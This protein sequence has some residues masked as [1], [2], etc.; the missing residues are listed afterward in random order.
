MVSIYIYFLDAHGLFLETLGFF[1][2][3]AW[4]QI[5]LLLLILSI[6]LVKS[7]VIFQS[8]FPHPKSRNQNA[9]HTT[10]VVKNP[11]SGSPLCTALLY[12]SSVCRSPF[13]VLVSTSVLDATASW[14]VVIKHC[15]E[16]F[17]CIISFNPL[18]GPGSRHCIIPIF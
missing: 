10:Y 7:L 6:A 11:S 16:L 12:W 5:S 9:A 2:E 1:M 4:D 3:E 18:T 8:Q 14:I 13:W 15:A 17:T